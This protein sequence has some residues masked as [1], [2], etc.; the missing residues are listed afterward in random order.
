MNRNNFMILAVLTATAFSVQ[1][2]TPRN[3]DDLVGARASSGERELE[4]RGY[5]HHKTMKIKDS[6]IGYWWNSR[7][8]QCIAATTKDGRFSSIAEQPESMCGKDGHAS[9]NDYD[10]GHHG[11]RGGDIDDLVGMRARS[12]ERELED[13]G[14]HHRNTVKVKG[15]SIAYWWNPRKQRCIAATTKDGRYDSI[16]DQPES[17]CDDK[18]ADSGGDH[19]GRRG[20]IDDLV[21]MRASSGERELRDRGYKFVYSR[22]GSGRIWA[23]W[24]NRSTRQCIT[25]VTMDG[26]YDSI[27][28]SPPAD[29]DRR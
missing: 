5:H 4:D 12:G 29:C 25:V 22:K 14:Y 2:Q 26:R 9:N 27:T 6:A 3:L 18:R 21:G 7:R 16:M 24:W 17:M 8:G 13:R 20:N 23:N 11:G 1:A 28:D 10:R 15:N 19:H